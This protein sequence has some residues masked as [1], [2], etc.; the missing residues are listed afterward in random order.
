[1]RLRASTVLFV[2]SKYYSLK[3]CE[4][5]GVTRQDEAF[6][7][8]VESGV[9]VNYAAKLGGRSKCLEMM[10]VSPDFTGF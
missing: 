10:I 9:G 4:Q 5:K 7:Q 6:Y 8:P 1:M 2:S 3:R